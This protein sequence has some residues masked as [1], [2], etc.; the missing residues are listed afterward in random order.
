M[1]KR[2]ILLRHA[3]A[4]YA[5]V[6]DVE[7]LIGDQAHLFQTSPHDPDLT[8]TAL[9]HQ[10]GDRLRPLAASGAD[11][12]PEAGRWLRE[13]DWVP[14]SIVCS[15]ALRT[16]QTCLWVCEQL[17]EKAPTPYLDSR[18]YSA[19][20]A[21]LISIINETPESVQTMLVVGH[22]PTVQDVAMRLSAA[23]SDEDAVLAMASNYPPLGLCAFSFDGPWAELDGRDARLE[24]F[25]VPRATTHE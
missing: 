8:P 14:D 5:P 3:K 7:G 9:A 4:D 24:H 11:D 20:A 2:L 1:T 19:P 17:G 25:E 6:I 18:I 16:R 21:K 15:D 13:N 12:A 22:M 10:A 23:D